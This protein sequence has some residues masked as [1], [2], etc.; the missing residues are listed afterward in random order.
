MNLILAALGRLPESNSPKGELGKVDRLKL[1]R[2]GILLAASYCAIAIL[3][4]LI[5]S[6]SNGE[7]GIPQGLSEPLIG[8]LTLILEALRRKNAAPPKD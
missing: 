1:L 5:R 4:A 6:V 2:M 3:E 8:V 7:F